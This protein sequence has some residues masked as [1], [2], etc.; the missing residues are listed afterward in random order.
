MT[1]WWISVPLLLAGLTFAGCGSTEKT[2]IGTAEERFAHA[3]QLYDDGDYLEAVSEFTV[4]TLQFSGSAHASEAQFYLGECRYAR[5]EYLLAAFEY[6]Q[7]R[8]N[9]PA[10][11]RSAEAQ[12]KLGLC[13]YR[14]S[15]KIV[16]DQQYTRKA[17]DELQTFVEY[18][19]G[20]AHAVEADSL[21]HDLN[22]KLAQKQIQT[23]RLYATLGYV[24]AALF[25]FDD[26]IERYHDTEYGPLAYIE[27]TQFLID[28]KRY[29]DADVV[30]SR[31]ISLYPS[32]VLRGR[33]DKLKAEITNALRATTPGVS[34]SKGSGDAAVPSG[35]QIDPQ[36][37]Q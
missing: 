13:Y 27:K 34:G 10:S 18:Y 16:L 7:L 35:G 1:R 32:N 14:L 21:I 33:A 3:K 36:G 17:I 5:G 25:Y 22:T 15:P 24:K 29:A 28:R 11:S 37:V 12:F 19:P 31:F 23:A 30:I 6:Q 20:D 4:V 2:Q 26:V 9:Y 8:R